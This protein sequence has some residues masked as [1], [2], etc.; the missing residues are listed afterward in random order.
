MLNPLDGLNLSRRQKN[1]L[2]ELEKLAGFS[3]SKNG[4][5]KFSQLADNLVKKG[6]PKVEST[7]QTEDDRYWNIHKKFAEAYE[8]NGRAFA[9]F[10]GD[11]LDII[12][13]GPVQARLV[14]EM[15]E[16]KLA[17]VRRILCLVLPL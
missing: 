2:D 6:E 11:I 4:G 5:N 7:K 12:L 15:I 8:R 9:L 10:I 14:G 1:G 13:S 3:P 17:K 16:K